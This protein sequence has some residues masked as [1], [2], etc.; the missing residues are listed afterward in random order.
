MSLSLAHDLCQGSFP[1]FRLLFFFKGSPLFSFPLQRFARSCLTLSLVLSLL[2]VAD[3]CPPHTQY[4]THTI[5]T[6]YTHYTHTIHTLY[7]HHTHTIHTRTHTCIAI[8]RSCA[9]HAQ[10]H[11]HTKHT[12]YTPHTHTIHT[13][14]THTHTCMAVARSCAPSLVLIARSRPLRPLRHVA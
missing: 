1:F 7:A 8:A 12:L 2:L 6:P 9:P 4:Y 10:Y 3:R 14:Y 11:M 13:L 5:H